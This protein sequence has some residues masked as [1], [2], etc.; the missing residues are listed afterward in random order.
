MARSSAALP[1]LLARAAIHLCSDDG[2]PHL[3]LTRVHEGEESRVLLRRPNVLLPRALPIRLL[4]LWRGD[5]IRRG[6]RAGGG[7]AGLCVSVRGVV[8]VGVDAEG[9]VG[10]GVRDGDEGLC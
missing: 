9:R 5:R 4:V 6:K 1:A 7:A 10:E 8:V 2:P 3:A